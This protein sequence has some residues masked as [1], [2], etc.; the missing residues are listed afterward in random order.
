MAAGLEM[1]LRL[2][3]TQISAMT[4]GTIIIQQ[5]SSSTNIS[6]VKIAS[7][8]GINL[9]GG[10]LQMGNALTPAASTLEIHSAAVISSLS[11]NSANATAKLVNNSLTVNGGVTIAAG[12]LDTN[13][14][15]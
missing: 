7:G 12:T 1:I 4:A 9:T 15:I 13:N 11:V 5:A 6:E 14:L 3:L 2:E 10:T 8:N